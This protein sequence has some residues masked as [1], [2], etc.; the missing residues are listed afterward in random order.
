MANN[1]TP[2]EFTAVAEY[3]G[4]IIPHQFPLSY[5]S[6]G[7]KALVACM[8]VRLAALPSRE[9]TCRRFPPAEGAVLIRGPAP[10]V[11]G[12]CL[13]TRYNH[14]LVVFAP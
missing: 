4:G 10:W 3:T 12:F 5:R 8:V 1:E 2:E 14:L 7:G 13:R 9:R 11:E 6:S